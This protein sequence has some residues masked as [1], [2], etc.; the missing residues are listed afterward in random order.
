MNI[1]PPEL[2]NAERKCNILAE[3]EEDF[4][5]VIDGLEQTYRAN[6]RVTV[7][8]PVTGG[9]AGPERIL[10]SEIDEPEK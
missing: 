1:P 3:I 9:G 10:L 4:S 5:H 2:Q 7:I 6:I 8:R